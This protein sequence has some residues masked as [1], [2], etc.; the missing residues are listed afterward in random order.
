MFATQIDGPVAVIGDVHGQTDKLAAILRQLDARSDCQD[1]W[2]VLIGDLVDRGRDSRGTMDLVWSL[3]R[4]GRRITM[5]AGNHELAMAGALGLLPTPDYSDWQKRWLSHFGAEMTF[6]SYGV[7][8]G[9]FEA[10]KA[11]VPR[12][13]AHI[14][15]VAPWCVEHPDYFFVHAGLDPN[16]PFQAQRAILQKREFTLNQPGWLFSKRWPFEPLPMGCDKVV[17]SGHVPVPEVKM[18]RQ[19]MLIDTTGGVGGDLSC[20]LLPE[21][22]VLT[23]G[24]SR[25]FLRMPRLF[26]RRSA[27]V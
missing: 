1:R 23:S 5:I 6:E 12:D 25:S 17:I 14:L 19:R 22:K 8:F 26:G 18:D 16:M 11:A 13:H 10:L 20:V 2:I 3:F 15:A 4:E 7:P 24:E 9:D 21:R 27:K